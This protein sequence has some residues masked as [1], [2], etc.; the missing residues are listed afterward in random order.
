MKI[1]E[2]TVPFWEGGAVLDE[3]ILFVSENSVPACAKLFFEPS[4]IISVKSAD[5]KTEYIQGRDYWVKNR[6]IIRAE[7]S[8]I[9]FLNRSDLYFP[10]KTDECFAAKDGGF[11]LYRT[12]GFFH[13]YQVV[14]T[15]RHKE[16]WQ[17]D[18]GRKGMLSHTRKIL[19]A[20]GG[21]KLC[22]Y[23]D[24]IT[25]GCDGSGQIGI[26]P[27]MPG[28]PEMI[29]RE[30]ARR[31]ECE[32]VMVNTAVGGKQSDWGAECAEELLAAHRPDLAVIAFGMNDG[33]ERVAPGKFK[34]NIIRIKDAV[35]RKNTEAEFIFVAPT[36]ANPASVFDGRQREY[37]QVLN[38][39]ADENDVVINMTAL[40]EEMILR[41]KFEDMTGNNI[42]HPNDFLIRVYAQAILALF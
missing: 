25:A 26:P 35:L 38:S 18:I 42:N 2:L 6:T 40:H 14:V 10:E 1:E 12:K 33:T 30:L 28:W 23:G 7:N 21:L 41:K 37:F 20:G 3:T 29:R 39:C 15:Y 34:D 24:S 8:A 9:P 17:P 16:Q 22:F 19:N 31:Y 11:V 13:N 32:V 5:L 36:V 27:Y 4:E